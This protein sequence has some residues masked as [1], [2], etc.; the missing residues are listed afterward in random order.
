MLLMDVNNQ[1]VLRKVSADL[2]VNLCLGIQVDPYPFTECRTSM[3]SRTMIGGVS[4]LS[5]SF[6]PCG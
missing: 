5:F 4:P 2:F 1:G 6:A 3:F